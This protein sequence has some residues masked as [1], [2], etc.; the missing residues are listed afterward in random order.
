MSFCIYLSGFYPE[1]GKDKEFI[2]SDLKSQLGKL[3]FNLIAY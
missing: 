2:L 1:Y 3:A